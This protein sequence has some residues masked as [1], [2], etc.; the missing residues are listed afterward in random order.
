MAATYAPIDYFIV[1]SQLKAP[2]WSLY[3]SPASFFP[4]LYRGMFISMST[5]TCVLISN[6]CQLS[7]KVRFVAKQFGTQ[8][9]MWK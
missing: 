7:A 8:I 4:A 9:K 2:Y 3:S 5:V 1:I 6:G